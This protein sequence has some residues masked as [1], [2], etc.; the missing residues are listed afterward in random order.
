MPMCRHSPSSSGAVALCLIGVAVGGAGPAMAEPPAPSERTDTRIDV[1]L[2]L[3]NRRFDEA[4]VGADSIWSGAIT[5]RGM[6]GSVSTGIDASL[7][8]GPGLYYGARLLLGSGVALPGNGRLALRTGLG[9]S[10]LTGGRIGFGFDVPLELELT[11]ALGGRVRPTLLVRPSLILSDD[12]RQ[13]GT[14]FGGVDELEAT[15]AL[16]I[17]GAPHGEAASGFYVGAAYGE[18]LGGRELGLVIGI[19]VDTL[20][21]PASRERERL[22]K[23]EAERR[24]ASVKPQIAVASSTYVPAS[25]GT[26]TTPGWNGP[27]A[28]TDTTPAT[29]GLI[30]NDDGLQMVLIIFG[31]VDKYDAASSNALSCTG[32]RDGENKWV[33]QAQVT[34]VKA[35]RETARV[36]DGHASK[37]GSH[38]EIW[39]KNGQCGYAEVV[40]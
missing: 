15:V 37:V 4:A 24:K 33:Y 29:I 26:G 32:D 10:G 7:G 21:S 25:P 22:A 36:I 20:S 8:G 16:A 19:K 23:V 12:A 6:V 39:I 11:L 27:H 28:P 1:G 30:T 35:A 18:R 3:E 13:D 14:R 40:R 2:G 9:A 5:A 31:E 17:V 38:Y 34:G